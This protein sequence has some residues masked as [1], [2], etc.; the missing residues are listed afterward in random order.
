LTEGLPEPLVPADCDLRGLPWM[1][2]DT[3]R[4]LD[5]D[6][7]ALSTPEEFKVA[8][9][10]W[11]KAWQQVPAA[12]LPDNDR[13]LT[14]LSGADRRWP[15]LKSMALRGF[16]K[17][18]DG[19]LYHQVIAEKALEAW[20]YRKA[21]RVRA[22]K[23]WQKSG[24]S[25]GDAVASAAAMQGTGTGTGTGT[26]KGQGPKKPTARTSSGGASPAP[27]T[28]EVWNAYATAYRQRYG[29]DPVRNAKVNAQIAQFTARVPAEDAAA[30]AA[31]YVTHNRR[32]YVERQHSVGLMLIDAEG[33]ATQWAT[34]RKV[35]DAEARQ[36]DQSAARGE[37]ANRL[38]ADA[39]AMEES[40]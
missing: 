15:K 35:M 22:N 32:Q 13:I 19:R 31:F 27:A 1:P 39:D 16:V 30:I 38:L 36:A 21:Q 11:M 17:C 12:S 8:F 23:R 4:L 9:R 20:E 40:A 28:A 2:I 18:S 25:H 29:V 26:G 10:L 24:T 34:G 14:E 5:S 33:L 37:Q 7:W 3:V 6:L